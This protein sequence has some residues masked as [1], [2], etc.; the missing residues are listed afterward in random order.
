VD[1]DDEQIKVGRMLMSQVCLLCERKV[2]KV[3]EAWHAEREG[4]SDGN[5]T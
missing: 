5:V 1:V 2:R 3:R 4:A